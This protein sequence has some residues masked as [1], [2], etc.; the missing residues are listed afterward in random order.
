MI[1]TGMTS[2][3]RYPPPEPASVGLDVVGG[4]LFLHNPR[5]MPR[6]SCPRCKPAWF[7][8]PEQ[9]VAV[10]SPRL[11]PSGDNV[12]ARLESRRAGF[13]EPCASGNRLDYDGPHARSS[14]SAEMAANTTTT[15]HVAL[16]SCA[17]RYAGPG[18]EPE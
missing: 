5:F 2:P 16:V 18:L 6:A 9:P 14:T 11:R 15:H 8:N 4:I 17:H 7:N 10:A 1:V 3:R 13:R 12:P